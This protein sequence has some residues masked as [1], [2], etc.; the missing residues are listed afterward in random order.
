MKITVVCGNGLGSSLMMEMMIKKILDA[1]SID[2]E[3]DHVDLSSVHG[4][5]SDI[6]IGTKDITS[7]FSVGRGTIVSLDNIVNQDAMKEKV[8]AAIVQIKS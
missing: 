6:Y 4:T 3:I 1:E 8:M 2:Y 5:H 7:Q